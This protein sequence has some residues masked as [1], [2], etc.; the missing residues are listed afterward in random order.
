[1]DSTAN[2]NTV[3]IPGITGSIKSQWN[4]NLKLYM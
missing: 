2:F 4:L 1:M 3:A